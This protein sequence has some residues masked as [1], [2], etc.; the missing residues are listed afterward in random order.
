[1]ESARRESLGSPRSLDLVM[2]LVVRCVCLACVCL[3][4][5]LCA[6]LVCFFLCL[7]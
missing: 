6:D 7:V 5:D 1:M 2:G 3:L 4:V